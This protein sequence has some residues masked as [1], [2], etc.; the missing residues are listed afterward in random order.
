MGT[1]AVV[2]ILA[3]LALV[4]GCGGGG[5]QALT[6][7]SVGTAGKP[8]P[9]PATV[10]T[11]TDLGASW[12][13]EWMTPND[14]SDAGQVVGDVGNSWDEAAW[15]WQNGTLKALPLLPGGRGAGYA[16][17]IS[18]DGY[19]AGRAYGPNPQGGYNYHAVIW[20]ALP[21]AT[22][23]ACDLAT[24]DEVG[25]NILGHVTSINSSHEAVG[26]TAWAGTGVGRYWFWRQVASTPEPVFERTEIG[27]EA[28]GFTLI[29]INDNHQAAGQSVVGPQP[30]RWQKLGDAWEMT[31]IALPPGAMYGRARRT[32]AHGDVGGI[33]FNSD[34]KSRSYVWQ[35]PGTTGVYIGLLA[36]CEASAVC[37][38]NDSHVIVGTAKTTP[39]K[40]G[41]YT[42]KG[43]IG[44][45]VLTG[46][47]I[48]SYKLQ[49]L[50]TLAGTE[51]KEAHAIN[52]SGW[53]ACLGVGKALLLRP[54]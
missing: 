17:G 37:D 22:Y 52:N 34:G 23:E 16:E 35:G 1:L 42:Y 39:D 20:V 5:D 14:I 50:T 30:G 51:V 47:V 40:K 12:P 48:T 38:I 49:D 8:Q 53:I 11:V 44:T 32:N 10:Y 33:Y 15:V 24:A 2:V 27:T 4:T 13:G 54:K 9:P 25:P 29:D 36:G 26:S 31:P 45:P 19:I 18:S 41:Q 3:T 6:G 7:P 46:G 21:D 43:F 28:T